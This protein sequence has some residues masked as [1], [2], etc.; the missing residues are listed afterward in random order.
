MSQESLVTLKII[1]QH[2]TQPV[3]YFNTLVT[4]NDYTVSEHEMELNCQAVTWTK[5]YYSTDCHW[6][7][8]MPVGAVKLLEQLK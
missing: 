8:V 4:G 6:K 1:Q 7:M 2:Q 5:T 3:H